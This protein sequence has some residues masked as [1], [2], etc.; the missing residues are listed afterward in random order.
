M[1]LLPDFWTEAVHLLVRHDLAGS[2]VALALK[3]DVHLGVLDV[4]EV[5]PHH[6]DVDATTGNAL[7]NLE[8]DNGNT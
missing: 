7:R 5:E 1:D 4:V 6:R 2:V 3:L 8:H